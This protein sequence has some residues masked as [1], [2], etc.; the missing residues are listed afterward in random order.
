MREKQI[1]NDF[2]IV[3]PVCGLSNYYYASRGGELYCKN[4]AE[5]LVWFEYQN[6]G[7][8]IKKVSESILQQ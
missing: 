1:K 8:H 4:C 6:T 2:E 7:I 5:L 3:C